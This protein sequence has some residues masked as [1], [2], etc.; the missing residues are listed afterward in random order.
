M[1][2][3]FYA[4][5]RAVTGG[6]TVSLDLGPDCTVRQML[7]SVFAIFPLLRAKLMDADNNLLPHVHVFINGR[8][9]EYLDLA[10]ETPIQP[11]DKLDIFPAVGGG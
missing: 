10:M 4:T 11:T 7:E 3:H 9:V 2:I 1:D 6:K 8:D 5:L